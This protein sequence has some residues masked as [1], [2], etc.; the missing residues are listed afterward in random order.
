MSAPDSGRGT[1]L[2]LVVAL[3]LIANATAMAVSRLGSEDPIDFYHFWGI[4]AARAAAET[5]LG[6]PWENLDGYAEVL[7]DQAA[8]TQDASFSRSNQKRRSIDPTSPPLIYALFAWLP[9]DFG[10]ARRLF[11]LAQIGA[12]VAGAFLIGRDRKLGATP[13]LVFAGAALAT[14]LPF[15]YDARLGNVNSFQLLAVGAALV[16][17]RSRGPLG[18]A[19]LPLA[20][21]IVLAKPNQ[22]AC[23]LGIALAR[24]IRVERPRALRELGLGALAALVLVVGSGL[25]IGGLSAWPDWFGYLVTDDPGKLPGYPVERGMIASPG[26]LDLWWGG[27]AY[28]WAGLLLAAVGAAFGLACWR[29]RRSGRLRAFL[30]EPAALG[31]FGV[32]AVFAAGPLA[33]FHYYVLA[34]LP[35]LHLV[36]GRAR[37]DAAFFAGAVALA[38]YWGPLLAWQSQLE[39]IQTL[40][41]FAWVPLLIGLVLRAGVHDADAP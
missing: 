37:A 7:N 3:A 14:F 11:V 9:S 22:A 30:G 31:S 8:T 16:C 5:D 20:A 17:A 12:F 40:V 39:G 25:W 19:T 38:L 26:R 13:A 36:A 6:Q 2:L 24:L 34:L 33:W 27:G 35:A 28:L 1:R 15:A 18:A 21:L 41:C 23:A 10:S 32:V 4:Q 29:A